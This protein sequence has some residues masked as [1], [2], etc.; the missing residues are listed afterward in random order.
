MAN[1]ARYRTRQ[2]SQRLC[3]EPDREVLQPKTHEQ[4]LTVSNCKL[5]GQTIGRELLE[6]DYSRFAVLSSRSRERN[7]SRNAGV[8]RN[9]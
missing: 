3:D 9:P 1:G 5:Q 2:P 8:S 6:K 7:C 4:K